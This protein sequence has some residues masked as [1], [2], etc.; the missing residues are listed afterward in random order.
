[1]GALGKR[2]ASFIPEFPPAYC[3]TQGGSGRSWLTA[4]HQTLGG[5]LLWV[6]AFK[7]SQGL[8]P[9]GKA[10]P[11]VW[12][13]GSL[14]ALP[15]ESSCCRPLV[16]VTYLLDF[17]GSHGLGQPLPILCNT[18]QGWHCHGDASAQPAAC[19]GLRPVH[20][21]F[22]HPQGGHQPVLPESC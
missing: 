16:P 15:S 4:A 7:S 17:T 5:S 13:L 20:L 18:L 6:S 14:Q 21:V 22:R 1:M 3:V 11:S 2:R 8:N 12:Q 9:V 19:Q 10:H